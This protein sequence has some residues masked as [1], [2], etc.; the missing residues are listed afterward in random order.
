MCGLLEL[1]EIANKMK[2]KDEL[3]ELIETLVPYAKKAEDIPTLNDVFWMMHLDWNDH[4]FDLQDLEKL[5]PFCEKIQHLVTYMKCKD[6]LEKQMLYN[7]NKNG[8]PSLYLMLDTIQSQDE[9]NWMGGE[10]LKIDTEF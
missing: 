4:C 3:P 9:L 10:L 8:T 1:A 2:W 5:S 7:R 6:P